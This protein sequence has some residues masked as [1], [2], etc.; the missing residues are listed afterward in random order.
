MSDTSTYLTNRNELT[1]PNILVVANRR[2]TL[3]LFRN[4]NIPLSI[5]GIKEVD[6]Q[7]ENKIVQTERV[8]LSPLPSENNKLLDAEDPLNQEVHDYCSDDSVKDPNYVNTDDYYS[9]SDHSDLNSKKDR[10]RNTE[11]DAKRVEE[12]VTEPDTEKNTEMDREPDREQDLEQVTNK[13]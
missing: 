4:I 3:K 10:I 7:A 1:E 13:K 11:E 8:I 12:Q 6:N 5:K 9:D 2:P